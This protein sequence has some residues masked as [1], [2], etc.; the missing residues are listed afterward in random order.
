MTQAQGR[1][2]VGRMVTPR[3]NNQARIPGVYRTA[4]PSTPLRG[5]D[6][7]SAATTYTTSLTAV[8][9][10]TGPAGP[11]WARGAK[12][13]PVGHCW[14]AGDGGPAWHRK[15]PMRALQLAPA[16]GLRLW[17]ADDREVVR[18]STC[19]AATLQCICTALTSTEQ[20]YLQCPPVRHDLAGRCAR[21]CSSGSK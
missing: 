11:E 1:S 8:L 16:R 6:D 12:C 19:S 2:S 20:G 3:W 5:V 18:P 14:S 15:Q 4:V 17:D 21:L 10:L 9:T 7:C 13:A